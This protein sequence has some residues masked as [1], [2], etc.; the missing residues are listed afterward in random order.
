M[1]DY[2][3]ELE[4]DEIYFRDRWQFEQKYDFLPDPTADQSDYRQEFYFFIPDALQVNA[5]TY[6]SKQFYRDLTNLIRLKTPVLTLQELAD[7]NFAPSPMNKIEKLRQSKQT[8]KNRSQLEDEL[9]LLGNVFRSALRK[10]GRE[11]LHILTA[12]KRDLFLSEADHFFEELDHFLFQYEH[13]KS[14]TLS[15][16]KSASID[17]HFHY[18]SR[19][20]HHCMDQYLIQLLDEIRTQKEKAYQSID[21]RLTNLLKKTQSEISLDP[22]QSEEESEKIVYT[23]SLLDK[24]FLDSLRLNIDH[25]SPQKKYQNIV[26]AFAA[27][28]AMLVFS[29]L[30]M[31]KGQYILI[32][33]TPFIALTVLLYVLKDRI[34]EGIKGVTAHQSLG[35]MSDFTTKIRSY[36][37]TKTLGVIRESFSFVDQSHVPDEITQIRNR[38]FHTVVESFKRPETVIYYQKKIRINRK[39]EGMESRRFMLNLIFRFNVRHFLDKASNPYS[40]YRVLD[41]SNNQLKVLSMPKVYHLNII[42]KTTVKKGSRSPRI[43]FRKV[44]VV[45]DKN[46]IK[47]IESP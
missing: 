28:I 4:K 9:K 14:Q 12:K 13:L 30:F 7:L 27:A 34:K 37:K 23:K 19:F 38:E 36:D 3:D 6:N 24:F 8:K 31:W 47:R 39:P 42:I 5:S 40:P 25:F 1:T 11:L 29:L 21:E 33:S 32:D 35:W 15:E 17:E 16:W 44:R 46:G 45:A 41:P 22:S 2:I 43:D 18:L 20:L 10:K 26:G